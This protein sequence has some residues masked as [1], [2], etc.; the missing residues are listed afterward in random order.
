MRHREVSSKENQRTDRPGYG[1]KGAQPLSAFLDEGR[2]L[3]AGRPSSRES[4]EKPAGRRR[5]GDAET[6]HQRKVV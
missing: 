6:S 1:D 3:A 5:P 4:V 2:G